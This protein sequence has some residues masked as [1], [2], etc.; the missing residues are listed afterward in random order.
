VNPWDVVWYALRG[1]Q[2]LCALF[3]IV[4]SI[5]TIRACARRARPASQRVPKKYKRTW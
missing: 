1:I 3:V 4:F 2:L 5:V